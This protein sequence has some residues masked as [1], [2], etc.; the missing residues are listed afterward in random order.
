MLRQTAA[1]TRESDKSNTKNPPGGRIFLFGKVDVI[2]NMVLTE[3]MIALTAGT[4][5][6]LKIRKLLVR[7]A[8]D[9]AF[10]LI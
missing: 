7:S 8:A 1:N 2:I 3:A 6:K 5:T 9:R 4:V 10:V